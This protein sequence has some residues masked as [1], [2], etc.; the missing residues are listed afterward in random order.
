MANELEA[1]GQYEMYDD[2][3]DVAEMGVGGT[4][5]EVGGA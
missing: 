2:D 3:D 4:Y 5:T 1:A